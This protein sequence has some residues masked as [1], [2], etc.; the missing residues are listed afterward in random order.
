[1]EGAANYVECQ[2]NQ[3][4]VCDLSRK[5]EGKEYEYSVRVCVYTHLYTHKIPVER[6]TT[7][8]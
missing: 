1:M 8:C 6:Y 4:V 5:R 2:R 3:D 7:N